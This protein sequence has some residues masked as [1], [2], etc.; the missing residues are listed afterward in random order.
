MLRVASAAAI[1]ML[2]GAALAAMA[3]GALGAAGLCFLSASLVIYLQERYVGD[4]DGPRET[5]P[6]DDE[7]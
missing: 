2:F 3:N 4:S 5:S 7:R 1:V 6:T